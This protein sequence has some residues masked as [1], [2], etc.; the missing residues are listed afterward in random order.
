MFSPGHHVTPGSLR[1]VAQ[2]F[3]HTHLLQPGSSWP[4]ANLLLTASLRYR[5]CCWFCFLWVASQ[6]N[7]LKRR[8]LKGRFFSEVVEADQGR[9]REGFVLCLPQIPQVK[10][11]LH[12]CLHRESGWSCS[13]Q[14]FCEA[15][16]FQRYCF[17]KQPPKN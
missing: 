10:L 9:T 11:R 13:C 3:L 2:D 4:S 1:S 5:L 12:S 7:K 16:A 6:K 15:F 14:I 8:E 17:G